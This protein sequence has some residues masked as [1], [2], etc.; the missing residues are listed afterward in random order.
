MILISLFI[1]HEET[2]IQ[3]ITPFLPKEA[4]FFW[5]IEIPEQFFKHNQ[6]RLHL[7]SLWKM[8]CW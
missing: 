1:K 2:T 5:T 7:K 4:A 8:A 3:I 6:Y